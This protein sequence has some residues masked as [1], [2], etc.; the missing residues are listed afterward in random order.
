L[1]TDASELQSNLIRK[2]SGI[3]EFLV[4]PDFRNQGLPDALRGLCLSFGR[5]TGIDCRINIEISDNEKLIFA[6]D[7]KPLQIFRIVQEA[8]I[9]IE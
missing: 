9:N 2:V 1:C 6:D 5:R 4:P 3:C 7:E 8:L